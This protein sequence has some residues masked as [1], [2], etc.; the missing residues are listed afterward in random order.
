M[1]KEYV[2]P[3]PN[4]W[5]LKRRSYLIYM[6]R[7]LTSVFVLAYAI[8]LLVMVARAQSAASFASFYEWLQ[9]PASVILHVVLLVMVLFHAITWIALTPKVLI[10]WRG[11]Q[12]VSGVL[13]A[14]AH[15]AAWLVM[16]AVIAW[17][18]LG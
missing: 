13:I 2:R 12:R 4:T 6:V 10:I 7:E 8:V 3:F 11:E 18:V 14:G 16:S 5:W 9:S 17:I 15:Y 1:A